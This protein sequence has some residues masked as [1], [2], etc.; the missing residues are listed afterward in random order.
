MTISMQLKLNYSPFHFF[1]TKRKLVSGFA[2]YICASFIFIFLLDKPQIYPH[3]IGIV[4]IFPLNYF[5]YQFYY[6]LFLFLNQ[7]ILLINIIK[8]NTLSSL[9]NDTILPQ[10][11]KYNLFGW[12]YLIKNNLKFENKIGKKLFW[13][14]KTVYILWRHYLYL[15]FFV[16][17]LYT[18]SWN[19][20]G[21]Y[22]YKLYLFIF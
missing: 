9:K 14:K 12:K 13:K 17:G 4:S 22:S 3:N 11:K 8:L 18:E 5:L 10:N 21:N 20:C 16:F 2:N 15:L 1:Y 7:E 19:K 6:N